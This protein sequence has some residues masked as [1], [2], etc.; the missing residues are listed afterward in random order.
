MPQQNCLAMPRRSHR[1]P[2]RGGAGWYGS[3]NGG[4]LYLD[5]I[6]DL[7]RAL[8]AQSMPGAL[9]PSCMNTS[10]MGCCICLP[11]ASAPPPP[12]IL[13]LAEYFV[14]MHA[15]RLALPVPTLA[16]SAEALMQAYAWPGNTRELE[17]AIHF[18]LLVNGSGLIEADDISLTQ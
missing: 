3:A 8:Q 15:Q 10:A 4:T 2:R 16:D 7:P 13:P 12:D 11:C 5:E 1:R 18:A 6:A 17:N 9:T 14:A